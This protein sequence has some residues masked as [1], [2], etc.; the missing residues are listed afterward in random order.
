MNANYNSTKKKSTGLT[1]IEVL[2]T[3]VILSIGLLGMAAL[4][5]T[6]LRSAN[7]SNYRTQA[8]LLANDMAERMRANQAAVNNNQF[9]AVNSAAINC[10]AFPAPYCGQHYG[11]GGEVAAAACTTDQ[12]AAYDLNV[13]FCGGAN[14]SGRSGGVRDA[15]LSAVATITCIDTDPPTGADADVCTD[16]SPHTITLSWNEPNPD[17][18]NTAASTVTQ[19]VSITIRP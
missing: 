12:M 8:I 16:R 7:S 10:A 11:S 13:W 5:L 9:I 14:P 6:G 18:S 2:V 15:L 4:Q 1:M 19:S 3:L 17:H